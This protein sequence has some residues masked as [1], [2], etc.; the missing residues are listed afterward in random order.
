MKQL[1]LYDRSRV[2]TDW[3]CPRKRFWNYEYKGRGIVHSNTSLELFLGITVHDALAAI[4]HGQATGEVDIDTIASTAAKQTLIQ[5]APQEGEVPDWNFA[6]EQAALVEGLVRG[7]YKQVW[8][9]VIATYPKI[10]FVEEEMRYN[11]DNLVFMS[12][13]DL[14][15][16]ND[17]ETVYFEYKTTSSKKEGW[18]NSWDTAVQLHSTIMA[19]K[20][21]K[22]VMIDKVVV[23]GLYKGYVA[24]GKQTSPLVYAY[25]KTGTPPFSQD[26][27]SYEYKPGFKKFPTWEMPGGVKAWVEGMP[28]SVLAGQ[29]P[30]TPPIFVNLDMVEKFFVQRKW[31]E[32]E[33]EMA[34]GIL[35]FAE[36]PEEVAGVMEVAFPQKFDQCQPGW[37]SPCPYQ[38]L[39]HGPE[40][41]PLKMG[42]EWRESHHELEARQWEEANAKS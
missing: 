35:G 32:K 17:E 10:L 3:S 5:L 42:F 12:K 34:V 22:G 4:A 1:R 40:G 29:F 41:D 11:H 27:V 13:P 20:A 14:V 16:A 9:S 36:T 23:Q 21:T 37:G 38:F 24:M 15:L 8:P 26:Q 30:Q 31:R 18:I 28:S 2:I 19:V 33:I 6:R 7:F 25:K 39:C